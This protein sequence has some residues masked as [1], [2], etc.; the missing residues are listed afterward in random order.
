MLKHSSDS[1]SKEAK[2]SSFSTGSNS[3]S[4]VF[5]LVEADS[6]YLYRAKKPIPDEGDG[7]LVSVC[8]ILS[9]FFLTKNHQQS[10]GSDAEER[11]GGG[12]GDGPDRD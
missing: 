1:D 12:L 3:C 6:L 2:Q 9:G 7:S 8:K 5:I 4:R 10:H 11:V